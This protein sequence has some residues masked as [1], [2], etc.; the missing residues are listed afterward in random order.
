MVLGG[1]GG[2]S[3][4]GMRSAVLRPSGFPVAGFTKASGRGES[5]PGS[6]PATMACAL[7]GVEKDE[8][9]KAT[10][11]VRERA[12]VVDEDISLSRCLSALYL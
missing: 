3:T 4:D 7:R 1:A 2:S 10:L 11:E 9:I 12:R 6:A 5:G 8:G